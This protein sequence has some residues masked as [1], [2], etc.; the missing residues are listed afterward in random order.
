MKLKQK[1]ENVIKYHDIYSPFDKPLSTF[2]GLLWVRIEEHE[3]D[4][5]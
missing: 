2:K 5:V 1:F 4:N 3:I